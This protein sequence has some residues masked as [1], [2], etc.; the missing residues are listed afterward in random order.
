MYFIIA[1]LS[2]KDYL[3]GKEGKHKELMYKSSKA[4]KKAGASGGAGLVP[5]A[6]RFFADGEETSYISEDMQV[7]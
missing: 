2:V 6:R 1:G 7:G 3:E 5:G 4:G